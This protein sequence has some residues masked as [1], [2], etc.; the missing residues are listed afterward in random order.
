MIYNFWCSKCSRY[1][2]ISCLSCSEYTQI[3]I[4]KINTLEDLFLYFKD[5]YDNC[6]DPDPL[7]CKV[8][9]NMACSFDTAI[10]LFDDVFNDTLSDYDIKTFLSVNYPD[11]LNIDQFDLQFFD[12][13]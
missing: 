1:C 7:K 9:L 11:F 6:E 12:D 10:T 13:I 5:I 4:N 8:R 3:L 2:D